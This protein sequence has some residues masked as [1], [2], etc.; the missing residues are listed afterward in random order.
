MGSL[1]MFGSAAADDRPNVVLFLIDDLGWKNLGCFGAELYETPNIDRL[2]SEGM[3]FSQAYTSAAIC[4]PAR[5]SILS[6]M[7]PM[8]FGMWNHLH[9]ITPGTK[10]LP[11]FLRENG[12]QTWHVGKWHMGNAE[13][14]TLPLD[15]GFEKS[16]GASTA[17]GPGS[18]FWPFGCDPETGEPR[19]ERM[20]VPEMYQIGKKGDQLTELLTDQI[21]TMME[22]RDRSR[23]FFLNF[24]PYSVHSGQETSSELKEKYQ[25]KIEDMGLEPTY[26]ID[27][28]TGAKLLTSE[29]N[30][31]FAGM[32]ET[33]DVQIGRVIEMIKQAGEYENT[34][35]IFYSDN[36]CT[37]Q[38]VPCV[39]LNGGKN[40]TYEAG[41]RVPA[42]ISWKGKVPAGEEYAKPI[43]ICDVFDTVLDAV[44]VEHP[45]RE[46]DGISLMPVFSG[47]PLPPRQFVWYFPD[48]RAWWAQRPNAAIYDERSGMKYIS[49]FNGD[50]DEMYDLSNDLAE[51]H[52]VAPVHPE[53]GRELKK[54][55]RSFL[56]RYY[57]TAKAP[58]A[59][60]AEGVEEFLGVD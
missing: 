47:G 21:E 55:T 29:T 35:F 23:P 59:R 58:P 40:S 13:E 8:R 41:V 28:K 34:L 20:S 33:L 5:A 12:Y 53:L 31:V 22:G 57:S 37:T 25:R 50:D 24:W 15:M 17:F 42:F 1:L 6:G 43:Y 7:H 11:Q 38:N 27:P 14:K 2:C 3:R 26:R 19:H 51:A 32:V 52:N 16:A 46:D 45:K 54:R 18:Y 56:N 48:E 44:G 9:F 30:A 10:I 4:A 36:G 49:F 60:Y 39:P